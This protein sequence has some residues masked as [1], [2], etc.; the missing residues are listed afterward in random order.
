MDR[1]KHKPQSNV[2][3]PLVAGIVVA[4]LAACTPPKSPPDTL[5]KTETEITTSQLDA[6]FD[7]LEEQDRWR[8]S[9]ALMV[10]GEP[11]Y[12]RTLAAHETGSGEGES[13]P[14][15]RIGSITK[16]VTA[17]LVMQQIQMGTL[18]LTST[19]DQWFPDILHAETITIEQLLTHTSGLEN[20]TD[21]QEYLTV[22]T[23]PMGRADKVE[24]LESLKSDFEPGSAFKYSNSG[25]LLLGL[26]LEDVSGKS[27]PQLLQSQIAEPLKL[28]HTTF[29]GEPDTRETAPSGNL[30]SYVWQGNW[31]PAPATDLSV[32]GA[33]GAVLS[34]PQDVSR[35]F[36]ALVQGKIVDADDSLP[37]MLP[38]SAAYGFGLMKF[39]YGKHSG[40]GH[41]G[42][43]DGF[44]SMAGY[45]PDQDIAF[46]VLSNGSRFNNNDIAIA[47]LA[48]AYGDPVTIPQFGSAADTSAAAARIADFIGHYTSEQMPLALDMFIEEDQL[49]GQA[50]GQG[51]FP[52]SPV[53]KDT[54]EFAPA[55]L[56]IAFF[57]DGL[58]LYQAGAEYQFSR[59]PEN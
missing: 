32:P 33:A 41:T 14:V 18:S 25:Y 38:A 30:A 36:R 47:L 29:G 5:A 39:P 20:F 26:I 58:T 51:K 3:A 7:V 27:L 1:R 35:F 48:T 43:L 40:Y 42:G 50:T 54:F 9:V 55:G 11:I 52:L 23:Q 24:L 16:S 56:R 53:D 15:Y 46:A 22:H 37:K 10:D 28:H 17:A 8:G 34:T 57:Q 44:S 21:R 6:F 49:Y 2:F 12:Q 19:V 31:Q 59:Q 13:A 45:F 4:L